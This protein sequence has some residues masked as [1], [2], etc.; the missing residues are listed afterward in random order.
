[1]YCMHC[2]S[3]PK[4]QPSFADFTKASAVPNYILSVIITTKV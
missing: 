2:I 1:M 3:L 4:F